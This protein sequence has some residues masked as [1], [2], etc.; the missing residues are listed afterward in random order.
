[1]F[2]LV[3]EDGWEVGVGA[4]RG[5]VGEGVNAEAGSVE[6]V[7]RIVLYKSMSA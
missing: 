7:D 5:D 6:G 3:E 4:S 2:I 1:V